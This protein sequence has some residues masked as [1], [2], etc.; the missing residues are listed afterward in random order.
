MATPFVPQ[1]ASF[2]LSSNQAHPGDVLDATFEFTNAGT[3]AAETDCTVFVHLRPAGPGDPDTTPATG[4]DFRP[5]TSTVAWPPGTVVLEPHRAVTIPADF[6]PGSYALYVGFYSQDTGGRLALANADLATTGQR[7]KV[8][9]LEVKPK[10][11]PLTGQEIV[12]RWRDTAGLPT[13][14][15]QAARQPDAD[16]PVLENDQLRVVLSATRPAVLRY[17]LPD[18]A[19]L[20]GDVTGYPLRVRFCHDAGDRWRSVA[21][22]GEACKLAAH[23]STEARHAV[24]VQDGDT[25]AATCELVWRLEGKVLRV[26]IEDVQ[27]RNG[28]LL[29]DVWLP[30]VVSSRAPRGELVLPTLG[31]RLVRLAESQPGVREITMNWFEADLCGAVVGESAVAAVRTRDWDNVLE[32]RVSGPQGALSGGYAVRLPLR[33]EA[34]GKAAKVK[35]A[36]RP[37]VQVAVLARSSWMAAAKWLRQDVQGAPLPVYRDTFIYKIFCDSPGAKDYTTFEEALGIIRRVHDLAPWVKQVA[38]LV[39]WQY[40]GHDTGYPATDKINERL[41]GLPALQRVAAEAAKLNAVLSYHDNFDDAYQTSPQWD[42]AVIAR[43]ASG[44]LQKG[45]VWAGG[46]S[47]IL[48]LRKYAETAGLARVR[49]TLSQMP[50]RESYH[51]DVLSAVP[52]RRDYNPQAPEST[53][54]SLEGKVAIIRE[55]NAH[56]VDVTS[57]GFTAPFVGVIGHSW[58]FHTE[59]NF[60]LNGAEPVPFVAM[61]YHGGPTT[62]GHGGGGP[63]YPQETAL[64]GATYSADWTKHTDPHLMAQ[65]L[66]LVAL[67]WT[68]LRERRIE[69][70]QHRGDVRRLTYDDGSFVEVNGKSGQWRVVVDGQPLVENDLATVAQGDLLA[71]FAKTSRQATVKLPPTLCGKALT[72]T[73]ALT[74]AALPAE[75]KGETVSLELPASEPV[76]VRAATGR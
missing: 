15:E 60:G 71:V 49:R 11:Q 48:A 75:V 30:Q 26:N 51:I 68:R 38:Y 14:E 70:Y 16:G 69:D 47:Y 17:E 59:G 37:G 45:G 74:G 13:P 66:Y 5:L 64:I 12:R 23:S 63:T 22:R 18:G 57:E 56:G 7:Y 62:Y 42:P 50:V 35:L 1:L 8:A 6:P 41:G 76:L 19:R 2:R 10:D 24:T 32:A 34:H 61:I 67:P 31:G 72:A 55:F 36:E 54:D 40:E 46:Q 43:D 73:N 52:G 29:T 4:A 39:G 9:T 53:R 65:M 25:L 20:G 3:E 27:E 44:N 58:H 33:A 21:L 28:Y